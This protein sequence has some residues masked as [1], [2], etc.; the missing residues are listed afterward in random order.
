M[1]VSLNKTTAVFSILML[2]LCSAAKAQEQATLSLSEA[3]HIASTRQVKVIVANERVNQALSRIDQNISPL[4][5]Q[6]SAEASEKRQTRDLRSTGFSFP[7]GP[8]VGPFNVFDARVSLTQTIFDGAALSRLQASREGYALSIA[9]SRKAEQDALVL[10][11]NFFI[12]SRRSSESLKVY[13]A[14]LRQDKK[15]LAITYSRLKSGLSSQLEMK[16]VRAAYAKSLFS[17]QDAKTQA[18]ERQ[19]DLYAALGLSREH[20]IRLVWDEEI[21]Q[22]DISF[23]DTSLES[24]L[25]VVVAQEN[26]NLAREQNVVEKRGF[27]PK[28]SVMGDYGPSGLSPNNKDSSETYSVGVKATVPLFEGGARQA[29]IKE[30][31][32]RVRENESALKDVKR[33]AEAKILTSSEVVKR[34]QALLIQMDAD[35]SVAQEEYTLAKRKLRNGNGNSL[36]LTKAEVQLALRKDEKGEAVAFYFLAKVDQARANG[37]VKDFLSSNTK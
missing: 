17:W 21:L 3:L 13:D 15:N 5:P 28:V 35:I 14:M 26:F 9:E 32:S 11:A 24:Q 12:E 4:L 8:L 6:I 23:A 10:V 20:N 7:G 31:E 1:M 34:A 33:H 37:R 22:K 2:V 29:H 36:D 18:L 30:T 19:L 25:D 27:W 16:K